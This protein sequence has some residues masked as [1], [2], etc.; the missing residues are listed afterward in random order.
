[1]YLPSAR[2]V[3]ASKPGIEPKVMMVNGSKS[4]CRTIQAYFLTGWPGGR[5]GRRVVEMMAEVTKPIMEKVKIQRV[6]RGRL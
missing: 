5:G 3:W 4:H 2:R 6:K 1:M